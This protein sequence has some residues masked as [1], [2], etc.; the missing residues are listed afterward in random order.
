[1][2]LAMAQIDSTADKDANLAK[3][4]AAV[5][6]AAGADLVVFPEFT[7]YEHAEV[8]P[9]FV[10]AAEPLDGPFCTEL[11]AIARNGGVHL[12]AGILESIPGE[13]RAYN[14]IVVYAPSGELVAKYRKL[15]LYDAFGLRE[16]DIIRPG[17]DFEP[18][19][20]TVNGVKVG[21]MTCYDLRFPE[22]ARSLA[23]A[24]VDLALLPASWAPGHRKEDHLQVLTRA[25]AIE[26]TYF[27]ATVCQA[28]PMATGGSLLVDPMGIVVGELGE[29]P[30][31]AVYEIDPERVTQVRRKN[32]CLSNRR[33][34]VVARVAVG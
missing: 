7:M 30:A 3:V 15:H 34:G 13:N 10:E 9:W 29:V 18:V 5:A 31:L 14:T 24:G 28:P 4:R 22:S 32:P 20:F 33:F 2:K 6:D 25:R 16:S 11:A 17:E 21:V 1:M 12:A 26:N 23:D 8:G 19:T 27:L